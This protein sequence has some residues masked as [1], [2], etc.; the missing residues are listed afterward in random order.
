MKYFISDIETTIEDII[1][2]TLS[3]MI[4]LVLISTPI[5]VCAT[6]T[7]AKFADKGT[8]WLFALSSALYLCGNWLFSKIILYGLSSGYVASSAATMIASV[9]A[10]ILLRGEPI[11]LARIGGI[12]AALIAILLFALPVTQRGS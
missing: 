4:G 5:Y 10:A 1:T 7:L 8:F 3:S 2:A 9:S 11:T 6:L 12:F